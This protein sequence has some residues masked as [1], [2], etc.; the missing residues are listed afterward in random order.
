MTVDVL[1]RDDR[2]R[3]RKPAGRRS[4][5]ATGSRTAPRPD[6]E[7]RGLTVGGPV[8]E[9]AEGLDAYRRLG[10]GELVFVFRH[11]F[12]LETIERLGEVRTALAGAVRRRPERVTRTGRASPRSAPTAMTAGTGRVDE[13]VQLLV[14]LEGA[15][16]VR[17]QVDRDPRPRAGPSSYASRK[18]SLGAREPAVEVQAGVLGRPPWRV[19]TRRRADRAT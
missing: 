17:V 9:V 18:R 11:P 8:A 4:P 1:V 19:S 16:Q 3:P 14:D 7:Y 2:R 12:D 15:D 13:L 10:I 6:G 5:E